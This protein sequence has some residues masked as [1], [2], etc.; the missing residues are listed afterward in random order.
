M[1]PGRI[2]GEAFFSRHDNSNNKRAWSHGKRAVVQFAGVDFCKRR[3]MARCVLRPL[4]VLAL[5]AVVAVPVASLTDPRVP[6]IFF[7]FGGDVG[8]SSV[9]TGNDERSPPISIST[10]FPFLLGN[11]SNVF[12]RILINC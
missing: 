7:P 2:L 10:A 8:D 4:L 9:P 12:V 1:R 6:E 11:Y 5:S 3:A